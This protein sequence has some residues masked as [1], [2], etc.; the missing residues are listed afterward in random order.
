MTTNVLVRDLDLPL[1]VVADNRKL[2][3]VADG[4]PIF[5][6]SQLALDTTLVRR[7]QEQPTRT[8]WCS[9][10]PGGARNAGTQRWWAEE[11]ER[12]VVLAIEV[13]GRWSPEL[14]SFVAQL[15]KS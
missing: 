13:G 4:L 10:E 12:V 9:N 11:V 15:A 14:Q 6:G 1:P 2:E 5:G 7:T 8:E 3:V